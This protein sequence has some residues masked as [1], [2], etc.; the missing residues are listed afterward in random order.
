MESHVQVDEEVK[1]GGVIILHI[2]AA[3]LV[4]PLIQV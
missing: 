3:S 2:R 4:K 1:R